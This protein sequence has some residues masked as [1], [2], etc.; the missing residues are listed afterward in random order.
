MEPPKYE[1]TITTK[2]QQNLKNITYKN[3]RSVLRRISACFRFGE[4]EQVC[5]SFLPM[6][7][8]YY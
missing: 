6:E 8:S 5:G 7:K 4:W 1:S 3:V 2:E